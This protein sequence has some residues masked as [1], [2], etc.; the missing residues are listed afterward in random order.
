MDQELREEKKTV[1]PKKKRYL[2]VGIYAAVFAAVFILFHYVLMLGRIPS[3]S[4]EPTLMVHDWTVGSRLSY[5]DQMP[6]RG[7]MIIF[8]SDE[9]ESS[10]CKRVIGLPGEEVSFVGGNVYIDG[11]PLD[12]SAYLADDVVSECGESFTV[13]EGCVFVLGD[14]REASLDSRWWDDP[15]VSVDD[16][17]S[18]ILYVLPFHRLPW[19]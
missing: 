11:S 3:E 12:E 13:P 17:Q 18:K 14:N 7:D 16:I 19:F 1:P 4:M 10:L 2:E 9:E 5:R 8:Y 6:E 15:Y